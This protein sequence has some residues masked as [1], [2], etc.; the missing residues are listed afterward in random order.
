[1]QLRDISQA[2]EIERDSFPPPWPATNFRHDLISNTLTSYLVACDGEPAAHELVSHATRNGSSERMAEAGL[3]AL[4]A[5]LRR[6]VGFRGSTVES[7]R[8]ILGFIGLWFMVDEAHLSN[9]AVRW[10]HRRAGVGEHLVIAALDFAIDRSTSFMTLEVRA[11]NEAARAL[12][13]KC[14]FME[15]GVRHGYYSDNKEDA[16]LMTAEGITTPRFQDSLE[17]LR[18]AHIRQWGVSP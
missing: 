5:G 15:V 11:S 18:R 2:A 3:G 17:R 6:L 14:G 12:Y 13:G 16:V 9:I 8:L 10:S 4:K 1:M 7:Q